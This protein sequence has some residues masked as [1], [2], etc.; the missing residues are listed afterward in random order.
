MNY[1]CKTMQKVCGIKSWLKKQRP[2]GKT[3]MW[4]MLQSNAVTCICQALAVIFSQ[5]MKKK[6][7]AIFDVNYKQQKLLKKCS[8]EN[9]QKA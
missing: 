7:S 5:K 2:V 1:L 4:L 6:I 3:H 8:M 9:K